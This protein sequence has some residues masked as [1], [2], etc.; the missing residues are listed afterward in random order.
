MNIQDVFNES[1][2]Y[3]NILVNSTLL[4]NSLESEMKIQSKK[5]KDEGKRKEVVSL[6]KRKLKSIYKIK[7]D[8]AKELVEDLLTKD[9]TS[10]SN[11]YPVELIQVSDDYVVGLKEASV[12]N[13]IFE[14][15]IL[16][17]KFTTKYSDLLSVMAFID[18]IYVIDY[19]SNELRPIEVKTYPQNIVKNIKSKIST[20]SRILKTL[21]SDQLNQFNTLI[22]AIQDRHDEVSYVL[23]STTCPK[24]GK[25]I[26]ETPMSA[27]NLLFTRHQLGAIASS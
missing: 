14:N 26:E 19:E 7:D 22:R 20:Y 15:A 2:F 27:E 21:T 10:E 5:I 9:T 3:I 1:Y 18:G 16:D 25:E 4:R 8:K 24:C 6:Y 11:E 13:M 23:P 17:E 12:Y